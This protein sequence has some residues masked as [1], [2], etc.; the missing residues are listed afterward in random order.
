MSNIKCPKCFFEFD[1]K[2]NFKER[3]DG[4]ASF[5]QN[6]AR[7]RSEPIFKK[8]NGSDEISE[9]VLTI[10]PCCKN[11]F[12]FTEY[13]FFGFLSAKSVKIIIVVFILGMIFSA[14]ASLIT[15]LM[16]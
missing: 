10:C 14:I 16:K 7:I 12:P 5:I 2:K 4:P 3:I 9:A 8:R 6:I 13:R 1:A 11:E 15:K